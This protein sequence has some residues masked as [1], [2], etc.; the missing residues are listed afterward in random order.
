MK[1]IMAKERIDK[2]L[3]ERGLCESRE[4]AQALVMA[5]QVYAGDLKVVKASTRFD[6]SVALEVRQ[7]LAYVSRGGL[8][9]EKALD[10]F[11]LEP[12]GLVA[13]DIG[14]STGGFTDCLLQR[15]AARV[16]AVD[17]GKGHLAWMLRQDPRVEVRE[18]VNA[19]YLDRLVVP[20]LVALV[21]CDVSF[22]S[23]AKVLPAVMTRTLPDASLVCLI[24]P[25]FEAGREKVGKGGV[26]REASTHLEV[27]EKA[28][29]EALELGLEPFGL[30]FSPVRGPAGNIEYLVAFGGKS[31]RKVPP[32]SQVVEQ[33]HHHFFGKENF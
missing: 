7:G 31:M 20:E 15:G 29:S 3:V 21:V 30:T 32:A 5:G 10:E 27:L 12:Q 33:A 4:R 24:K 28:L 2:L 16:Y 8:K 26:V 6:Q 14:A 9:L 25:Q 23:L 18:G 22:I 13:L 11:A 1:F 17:V 19:R